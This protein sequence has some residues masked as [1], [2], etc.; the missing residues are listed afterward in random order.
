MQREAETQG[1]RSNSK[2]QGEKDSV[3]KGCFGSLAPGIFWW[4]HD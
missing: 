2:F 4:A 1:C 3:N